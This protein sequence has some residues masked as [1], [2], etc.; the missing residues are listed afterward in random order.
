MNRKAQIR[1][2]GWCAPDSEDPD[3]PRVWAVAGDWRQV[4]PDALSVGR[5]V[6]LNGRM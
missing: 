5:D 4:N 1:G 2:P 3:S 6:M